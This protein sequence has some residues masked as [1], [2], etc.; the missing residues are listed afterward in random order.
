M[1]ENS[2]KM[3]QNNESFENVYENVSKSCTARARGIY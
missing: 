3:R 2:A 1:T